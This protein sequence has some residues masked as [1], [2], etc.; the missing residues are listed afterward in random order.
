MSKTSFFCALRP[1][2]RQNNVGVVNV[3]LSVVEGNSPN[4]MGEMSL[5]FKRQKGCVARV[6][7]PW[8]GTF[9][10]MLF[11]VMMWIAAKR[12]PSGGARSVHLLKRRKH[13]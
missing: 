2:L 6:S 9:R 10:L 7:N 11:V 5:V 4:E 3:I 8:K 12:Y 1:M 13:R